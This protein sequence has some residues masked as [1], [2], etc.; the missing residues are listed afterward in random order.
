MVD[1]ELLID[2]YICKSLSS[3]MSVKYLINYFGSKYRRESPR[4]VRKPVHS[5][6][7]N[8]NFVKVQRPYNRIQI[9]VCIIP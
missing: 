4:G 3:Y 9:R 8:V 6:I 2:Y 5:S 7:L 1:S